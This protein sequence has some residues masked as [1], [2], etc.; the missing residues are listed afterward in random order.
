M[1]DTIESRQLRPV[2][3]FFLVCGLLGGGL[4]LLAAVWAPVLG[5]ADAEPTALDHQLYLN[6]FQFDPLQG[7]P[8]I[9][10][11]QRKTYAPGERG[12]YLLQLSGPTDDAWLDALQAEGVQVV[13]YQ[14]SYAYI[15]RMTPAQAARLRQLPFV[16]WQGI[17]EPAYRL[18]PALLAPATSTAAANQMGTVAVS[19][20]DDGPMGDSVEHTI[21]AILNLGGRL[22][23]QQAAAP[24]DAI[25]L[26]LVQLPASALLPLAQLTDVVWVTPYQAKT[27][28]DEMADQLTADGA[29]PT[30][31]GYSAWLAARGLD[32]SGVRL[33]LADTGFDTGV[34]ATAHP[35]LGARL[36]PI[37]LPADHTGH[38]THV[39][40]IIAGS[41]TL[42]ATDALGFRMG[43]GVAPGAQLVV[44][45]YADA[46]PSITR[47]LVRQGVVASNHSYTLHAAGEGYTAV[48]R[49]YDLLVRD[50][51]RDTTTV[52]EPLLPVFSAGNSGSSG[53]T[54]E[55]K[56]IL[57]VANARNG[58]SSSGAPGGSDTE[59]LSTSSSRGP[60]QDGRL[61]PHLAAPGQV[62]ISTRSSL[63]DIVACLT[64]P[65]GAPPTGP[66]YALCSGTSMAAPHV[67][68]AAGLLTQWWRAAHAGQNPSPAMLKALL[69][70]QTTDLTNEDGDTATANV[71]IPNNSE[72]WGRLSLT[73]VVQ[74]AQPTFYVDQTILF[75]ASGQTWSQR[76]QPADRTRPLRITLVW[77]DAPGPGS[78]GRTAA[79]VNDLDLTLSQGGTVY[80]GNYFVGG[81]SAPGGMA[82]PRNNVEMVLLPA[83]SDVY[84]LR[85]TAANIAGDGVPYN[86]DPTDQDFALVCYNCVQIAPS[87][88]STA[89]LTA[90]PSPTRTPSPSP[91]A[92]VAPTGTAVTASPTP[93]PTAAGSRR[94]IKPAVYRQGTWFL[95]SSLTSGAADSVFSYGLPTDIPLLCDWDGDGL[96]TVGVY[97][98]S[99]SAFYLRNSNTTGYAQT[100]L[101][102]G[103]PGDVPLCGDWNGDGIQTI[104]V[105]RPSTA[106]VYLRNS[107]TSGL[108]DA[109]F[110]YG[111]PGD[112]ALAG[113]WNGDGVDTIGVRRGTI[114]FLKNTNTN[115]PADL[116]FTYGLAS[117]TALVGDWDNDGVVSPGVYRTGL[118]LLRYADSSGLADLNLNFGL[119]G[120]TPA[121]WR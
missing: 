69:L 47:D 36:I 104:G 1:S 21:K 26:A 113:D 58:R 17:Y 9:P 29:I 77:S 46:E 27:L 13:Q 68:G 12:L 75:T 70:N 96:A 50:A 41:G 5:Q 37:G 42:D 102:F 14:A 87:P 107:N 23:M 94:P 95:R 109:S 52:A 49:D 106:A 20:F 120:D 119:A 33:G 34:A 80:H 10:S 8:T 65:Q 3:L 51:D 86:G 93:T 108:A 66:T 53:P 117:D 28:D 79:W 25:A 112:Q 2:R 88:T 82:D 40:G 18:S 11:A 118:W 6:R 99:T 4:W 60:T 89:T 16:R 54:K 97:R 111:Q 121:A 72:G 48:D 100:S 67:T 78:G 15:V 24:A 103:S 64:L 63:A 39:G 81:V 59:A 114:W 19:I 22:V 62:V 44:R 31:P 30:S 110:A 98:P 45:D 71:P 56:N 73:N 84:E 43:L 76:V 55:A 92:T 35:D 85:I 38:G 7:N 116:V 91:S 83:P 101:L 105:F 115:G 90:S 61:Y 57:T 32:G 74:P